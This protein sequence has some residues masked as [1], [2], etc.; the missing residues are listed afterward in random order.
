MGRHYP[1]TDQ[2]NIQSE[3]I[4]SKKRFEKRIIKILFVKKDYVN[5]RQK[6]EAHQEL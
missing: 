4:L 1:E 3:C 2:M 6:T 5:L